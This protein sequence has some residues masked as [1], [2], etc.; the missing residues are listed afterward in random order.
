MFVDVVCVLFYLQAH[1]P[2]V[3]AYLL[4]SVQQQHLPILT[5]LP[6]YRNPAQVSDQPRQAAHTQPHTTSKS[7]RNVQVYMCYTYVTSLLSNIIFQ[8]H[9]TSAPQ[10]ENNYTLL[11][12]KHYCTFQWIHC[13]T[14]P[15]DFIMNIYIDFS[16]FF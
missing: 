5:T 3:P 6:L 13:F 12:P 1:S 10:S 4:L 15:A 2:H 7:I 8:T 16:L 9:H 11:F 14:G